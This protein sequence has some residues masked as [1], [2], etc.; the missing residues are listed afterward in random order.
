MDERW[1]EKLRISN[2]FTRLDQAAA[3]EI[4]MSQTS[5]AAA[6]LILSKV[7]PDLSRAEVSGPDGG[8]IKQSVEVRFVDTETK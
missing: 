4:E 2:I 3:G 6:K 7:V 8:P 5:L 1:K